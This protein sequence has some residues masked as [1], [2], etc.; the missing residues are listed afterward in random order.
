MM[1]YSNL[2]HDYVDGNLAGDNE[3][4]LFLAM[5]SNPELRKD[6]RHF[7]DMEKA[8]GRDYDAFAPSAAATAGVFGALGIASTSEAVAASSAGAGAAK[9]GIAKLWSNFSQGIISGIATAGVT[10]AAILFFLMPKLNQSENQS[11]INQAV[12]VVEE[13]QPESGNGNTGT[14]G[15]SSTPQSSSAMLA[16]TNSQDGG[17]VEPRIIYRYVE[18]PA[19]PVSSETD[20]FTSKRE[21]PDA[22]GETTL[23]ARNNDSYS[24][25]KYFSSRNRNSR[26]EFSAPRQSYAPINLKTGLAGFDKLSVEL[27]GG[28]YFALETPE[29]ARSSE[30]YLEDASI[31]LMYNFSD[32]F[33]LGIEGRQE[34]FYQNYTGIIDEQTWRYSQYTNYYSAGISARMQLFD[35]WNFKSFAQAGAA[36]SRPGPIGRAMFGL[37]YSPYAGVDLILGVEG[38][39]LGY[40]HQDNYFYSPKWGV[41]YGIRFNL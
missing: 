26:P 41:N 14:G 25:D 8:A 32:R 18:V 10:T 21:V 40:R 35:V 1:D 30:P 9:T 39:V 15:K 28:E 37:Q 27:R 19:K 12:P 5:A 33:S 36:L 7:I 11:T 6:L 16:G 2:I 20:G 17:N 31:L 22:I 23:L 29:I 13:I 34:F 38:S 3:E 24:A 4:Q